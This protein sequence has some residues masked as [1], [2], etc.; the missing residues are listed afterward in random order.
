MDS[1]LVKLLVKWYGSQLF[2]IR[3]GQFITS[4]FTVSNGVRQGGLLSPF[5]YNLY[6]DSLTVNL[7]SAG[8]GCRYLE[9]V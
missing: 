1:H 7:N 6:V 5:L 3:W 8:V 9:E 2:H 4:G